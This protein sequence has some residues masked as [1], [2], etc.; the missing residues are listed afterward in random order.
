M[1]LLRGYFSPSFTLCVSRRLVHNMNVFFYTFTFSHSCPCLPLP[2]TLDFFLFVV[3]TS[4]SGFY[5]ILFFAPTQCFSLC[6]HL[7][8]Y[9]SLVPVVLTS[10][11]GIEG[12]RGRGR[13]GMLILSPQW[14]SV[15]RET[16]REK[17]SLV[18]GNEMAIA[19]C[20]RMCLHVSRQ[21]DQGDSL[22][23]ISVYFHPFLFFTL[24]PC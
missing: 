20:V 4:L 6:S 24:L 14:L 12:G 8:S 17:M 7:F 3:F 11:P 10:G 22:T 21:K 15:D 5:F 1:N 23:D 16:E 13:K 19:L 9:S 2:I 18:W